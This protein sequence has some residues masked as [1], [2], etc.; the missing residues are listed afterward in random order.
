VNYDEHLPDGFT[1]RDDVVIG[2]AIGLVM[3]RSEVGE[4]EARGLLVAASDRT[5]RTLTAVARSYLDT[6]QTGQ[7]F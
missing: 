6:G 2:I 4:D 5:G 7:D 3:V 1:D